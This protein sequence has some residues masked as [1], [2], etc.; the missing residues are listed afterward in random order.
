M[1]N[2]FA[3]KLGGYQEPNGDSPLTRPFVMGAY[4]L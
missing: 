1:R 2:S 3:P 4:N